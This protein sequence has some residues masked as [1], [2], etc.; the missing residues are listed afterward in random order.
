MTYGKGNKIVRGCY[1]DRTRKLL[2]FKLL[3]KKRSIMSHGQLFHVS[4][5]SIDLIK[6]KNTIKTYMQIV[7]SHYTSISSKTDKISKCV[8]LVRLSAP[9]GVHG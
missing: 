5:F 2:S 7:L 3:D 8:V 6:E 9:F 4:V 1:F